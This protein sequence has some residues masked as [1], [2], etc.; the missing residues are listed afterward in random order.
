MKKIPILDKLART[1]IRFLQV[2]LFL[3]LVSWPILLWWGLPLSG[4]TA[5]GNAL[6]TPFLTLYLLLSSIIFFC[7]FVFI[8]NTI[9]ILFLEKLTHLWNFCTSFSSSSWLL[10][11]CKP[12]LIVCF[13]IP[14]AAFLIIQNR[15][16]QKPLKSVCALFLLLLFFVLLLKL[17]EPQSSELKISVGQKNLTIIYKDSQVTVKDEGIRASRMNVRSWIEYTF[18][19]IAIKKIGKAKIDEYHLSRITSGSLKLLNELCKLNLVKKVILSQEKKHSLKIQQLIHE[20]FTYKSKVEIII[21]EKI[22]LSTF[23]LNPH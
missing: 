1:T 22:S 14:I 20:L 12:P 21:K 3:T 5:L 2:Q 9:F 16:L 13:I 15:F 19:P 11:M 17:L 23:F 7:E 18:L 6:F 10:Y 4:A 8:P